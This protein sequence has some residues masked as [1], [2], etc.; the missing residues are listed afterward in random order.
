[1]KEKRDVEGLIRVL[2]DIDYD[3]QARAF[4]S[5]GMVG[6]IIEAKRL[7]DSFRRDIFGVRDQAARALG[8]IEDERAVEALIEALKDDQEFIEVRVS[9]ALALAM[10]KDERA[11]EALI[12]A[13]NYPAIS[14]MV[15][16]ALGEIGDER[17]VEM[18]KRLLEILEGIGGY[19]DICIVIKDAL[20]KIQK[21]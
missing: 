11:V 17:A 15:A 9:A 5:L 12:E 3:V 7:M 2:R 16:Y 13:L 6:S 20:K 21:V 8:E 14:K 10:I 18:M 1:M 4:K 19:E